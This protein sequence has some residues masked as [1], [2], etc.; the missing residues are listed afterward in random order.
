MGMRNVYICFVGL[1]WVSAE[2]E[3]YS[4][5]LYSLKTGLRDIHTGLRRVWGMFLFVLFDSH[6]SVPNVM[7]IYISF[8]HLTQVWGIFMQVWGGYE[9]YLYLFYSPRMGLMD[10]HTA[11]GQVGGMFI[12]M[13]LASDGSEPSVRNIHISFIHLSQVWGMSEEFLHLFCLSPT[14]LIR[15]HLGQV[16]GILIQV[17]GRYEECFY[18]CCLP[19]MSLSHV[20]GIFISPLFT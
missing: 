19:Q 18:L 15:F 12:F 4:Y 10:I 20:W 3:E 13:L 17:W 2:C 1:T 16:W 8:I 6:R 7:N 5:V 9:A 14:G 11:L